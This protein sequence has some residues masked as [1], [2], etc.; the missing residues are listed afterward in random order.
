[1][2]FVREV[3]SGNVFL[4]DPIRPPSFNPEAFPEPYR[5]VFRKLFE[6]PASEWQFAFLR[7]ILL[8]PKQDDPRSSAST[9]P[10][11]AAAILA[12]EDACKIYRE[13][14][15]Q[16]CR[17]ATQSEALMRQFDPDS[18]TIGEALIAMKSRLAPRGSLR[19]KVL[20]LISRPLLRLIMRQRKAP[21]VG[22]EPYVTSR[23]AADRRSGAPWRGDV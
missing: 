2:I 7:D 3:I 9:P 20:R 23:K 8:H 11:F 13:K 1:M 18:Q 17:R 14:C 10:G 6:L 4:P 12:T 16:W 21:V 22:L 5:H 19:A 15:N